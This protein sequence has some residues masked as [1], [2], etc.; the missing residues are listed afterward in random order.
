MLQI[1]DALV[2]QPVARDHHRRKHRRETPDSPGSGPYDLRHRQQAGGTSEIKEYY[3]RFAVSD[4]QHHHHDHAVSSST[5]PLSCISLNGLLLVVESAAGLHYGSMGLL[6]DAGHNPS[7]VAVC[8]LAML[9]F[10]LAC[11]RM[12]PQVY[13]VRV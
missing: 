2:S 1:A 8:C 12:R 11:R 3:N 4:A 7:D 10:W 9:V 13:L 6:S 5:R